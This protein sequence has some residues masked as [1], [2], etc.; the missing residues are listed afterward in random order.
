MGSTDMREICIH[1]GY[2]TDCS[3]SVASHKDC[4]FIETD[5]E[6]CNKKY[7]AIRVE[8]RQATGYVRGTT[9]YLRDLGSVGEDSDKRADSS[10][11][12]HRLCTAVI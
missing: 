12:E 8:P 3:P 10:M 9:M 1:C 5:A 6:G 7:Q 11:G 4:Y 2:D